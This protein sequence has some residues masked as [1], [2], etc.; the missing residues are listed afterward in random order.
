M[1]HLIRAAEVSVDKSLL[2]RVQAHFL[3]LVDHSRL[4]TPV[5]ETSGVNLG[6]F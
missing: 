4:V 3:P 2:L 5:D 1:P 6:L